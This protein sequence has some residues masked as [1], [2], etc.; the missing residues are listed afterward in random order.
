MCGIA[1]V[2]ILPLLPFIYLGIALF[3]EK[4]WDRKLIYRIIVILL[5]LW[6]VASALFIYPHYLEYFNEL[7]GGP[8]NG[9]KYLLDSNLTWGQN[10][11]LIQDYIV[12]IDPEK[13]V[14]VN[15]TE[16]VKEGIVTYDVDILMGRDSAKREKTAWI[17]E[18]LLNGEIEPIDRIAYTHMVF[19]F[20]SE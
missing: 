10:S 5:G 7:V 12:R 4:I 17:R 1:G 11:F 15:P 3:V 8:K 19:E 18:P 14:Y 2:V 13:E 9:Y 6:Y 20:K 16:P